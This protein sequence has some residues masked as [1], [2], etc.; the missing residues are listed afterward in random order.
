MEKFRFLHFHPL[1]SKRLK[2]LMKLTLF[3]FLDS[4]YKNV[5]SCFHNT[6]MEF[7]NFQKRYFVNLLFNGQ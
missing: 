4:Y 6:V 5:Y 2:I 3:I 7:L 1:N